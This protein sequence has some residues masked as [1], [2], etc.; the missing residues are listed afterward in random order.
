MLLWASVTLWAQSFAG[1]YTMQGPNGDATLTL[2][3]AAGG[4]VQ[5]T[6]VLPGNQQIQMSGRVTNGIY[7]GTATASGETE[8]FTAR[9]NGNQLAL[10]LGANGAV[11]LSFTRADAPAPAPAAPVA[12]G[13]AEADASDLGF[14]FTPPAGWNA[15]R[16]PAGFALQSTS[17]Q[18]MILVLGHTERDI[19]KLKQQASE[20]LQDGSSVDLRPL[21]PP[22]MINAS[23]VGVD[24]SGT[25]QQQPAK[26]R[27]LAILSPHGGGALIIAGAGSAIYTAEYAALA[28]AVARSLR[29]QKVDA[30]SAITQWDRRLR[31][32]LL[33]YFSRYSSGGGGG[34]SGTSEH[35]TLNL[36]ADG[37]FLYR[38][39]FNGAINVPGASATV[40]GNPNVNAGRWRIVP[41][42]SHAA[43]ELTSAAGGASVWTLADDAG[44]TMLNGK[45][46]MVDDKQPVCR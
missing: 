21:G 17:K 16:V 20:G 30:S 31:G 28:D 11:Q 4:A 13:A 14:R 8:P 44:K 5:G 3:Q 26:A 10:A 45:R 35:N 41:Q 39:D 19:N 38:G 43:L 32:K 37:T 12:M 24:L 22:Q 23:T 7:S 42:A 29:F 36:C 18:G 2:T 1:R 9:F 27:A 34:F 25:I 6:L 33:H 40:G 46:W 15:Q